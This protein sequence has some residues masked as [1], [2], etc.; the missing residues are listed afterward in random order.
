MLYS[1][2]QVGLSKSG[3]SC[4][5]HIQPPDLYLTNY[6]HSQSL[7]ADQSIMSIS[8]G[9][10]RINLLLQ[11]LSSPQLK[12]PIIHVAGTNGKGS[13]CAY[14]DSILSQ[15]GLSTGRFNSP[16]LVT[17]NDCITIC[18][19]PIA[20]ELYT[21]HK[22][23][24]EAVNAQ[25]KI[26]ATP[27]ELL[28]ATAYEAFAQAHPALDCAIIETGMGGRDDATNVVPEPLLTILTSIELDHQA[29]LG[30]TIEEIAT[31]K[32]GIIK[33]GCPSIIAPQKHDIT[34]LI[35]RIADDK[36]SVLYQAKTAKVKARR[37]LFS[38][39]DGPNTNSSMR[40]QNYIAAHLPLQGDYQLDNSSTAVLAAYLLHA[41]PRCRQRV[42]QLTLINTNS[43]IDGIERTTWPGR[44]DWLYL[45]NRDGQ[46]L[47]MLV[48][49]AHNASSAVA[50][51]KYLST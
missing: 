7:A 6:T 25:H 20:I 43:I 22:A 27:F 45:V 5:Y 15:S 8:L 34:Q 48:D 3:N 13:V 33:E 14:L 1:P 29:F 9:L 42:P 36:N 2:D 47:Q 10:S 32:A 31:I 28:T 44:L 24:V 38:L 4:C 18:N 35:Q 40:H 46:K 16:H 49:G 37:A 21:Q 50:L 41:L 30:D 26:E 23:R 11:H 12:I 39:P 17:V 51:Q 19:R